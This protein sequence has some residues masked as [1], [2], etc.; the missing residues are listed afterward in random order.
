MNRKIPNGA[1]C[2]FRTNPVGSRQGKVVLV[3]HREIA[4]SETGGHYTVKVYES[5]KEI[6]PDGSWRH[7]SIVLR[8]DSS[9]PGYEEIVISEEQAGDLRVIAELVAVLG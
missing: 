3:Q 6:S 4:D 5:R 2:L 7:T 9:L 1:C 8:P